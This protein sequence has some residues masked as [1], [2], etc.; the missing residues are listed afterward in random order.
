ME[1]DDDDPALV[2]F[3]AEGIDDDEVASA[4]WVDRCARVLCADACLVTI[5][6]VCLWYRV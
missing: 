4:Y 5:T 2:A 6:T 3:E 1:I